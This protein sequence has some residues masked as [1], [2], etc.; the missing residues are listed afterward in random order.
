MIDRLFCLRHDAVISGNHQ[1]DNV[2]HL[3]TTG[4]HG[5]K[6]FMARSVEEGHLA[7]IQVDI[8]S[9]NMLGDATGFTFG[10]IRF[11]NCIQ[12]TGLAMVNMAHDRDHRWTGFCI[13]IL[14]TF[15]LD[16][17]VCQDCFLVKSDVFYF[18]AELRRKDRSRF[19]IKGMVNCHH[20]PLT[21]QFLDEIVR[22]DTHA[23][24]K[25]T[26]GNDIAN[27][28]LTLD[29]LRLGDF[30]FLGRA[31]ALLGLAIA[32]ITVRLINLTTVLAT[33]SALHIRTTGIATFLFLL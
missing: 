31:A 20:L 7:S 3:G 27:A 2:C 14:F 9:T 30:G 17:G 15:N 10:D 25:L 8:I 23:L 4:T 28:N 33:W 1:N 22:F 12:Q 16:I 26:N 24:G 32:L 6:S 19:V 29:R 11:T 21:H 18:I 13:R 5:C